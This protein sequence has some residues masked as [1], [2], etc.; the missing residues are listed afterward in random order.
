M[1]ATTSQRPIRAGRIAARSAGGERQEDRRSTGG[2]SPR[3][4]RDQEVEA[5]ARRRPRRA[6]RR[7]RAAHPVWTAARERGAGAHD[8][9]GAADDHALDERA[10]DHGPR[11]SGRGRRTAGRTPGRE[12]VEVPLVHRK[13]CTRAEAL[14][15]RAARARLAQIDAARQRR[16]R[17]TEITRADDQ[18]E[19]LRA[20]SEGSR[21]PSATPRRSA[22][23]SSR[24]SRSRPGCRARR[25]MSA[26]TASGA[27]AA[28]IGHPARRC[29]ARDRGSRRRCPPPRRWPGS[30]AR[31]GPG[32][33][34]RARA[35]PAT[36]SP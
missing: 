33:P 21:G 3:A 5:R 14:A 32:G 4:R 15:Q 17:A 31:R 12:L 7:M 34:A 18:A 29:G 35:P 2:W 23:G 1:A 10:L 8:A 24:A 22:R 16:C 13:S 26:S 30:R 6:A 20:R 19:P 36:G 28:F 11:R 9:H 25:A 27:I